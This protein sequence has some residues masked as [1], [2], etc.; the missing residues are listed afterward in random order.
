MSYMKDVRVKVAVLLAIGFVLVAGLVAVYVLRSDSTST[1][2]VYPFC[3]V[4]SDSMRGSSYSA[5]DL[6]IM[7]IGSGCAAGEVMVCGRVPERRLTPSGFFSAQCPSDQTSDDARLDRED[8]QL[9]CL[10]DAATATDSA[11]DL[12]ATT[13]EAGCQPG[14]YLLCGGYLGALESSFVSDSCPR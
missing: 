4:R 7:D 13:S 5:G 6:A 2:A 12:V 1:A 3:V 9:F 11:G 8:V 14:Q 10:L